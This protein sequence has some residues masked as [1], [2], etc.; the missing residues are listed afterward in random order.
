M[1]GSSRLPGDLPKSLFERFHRLAAGDEITPVY[2]YGRHR[3]DPA[4][5]PELLGLANLLGIAARGEY[6]ARGSAVEA[7]FL[8]GGDQYVMVG[9]ALALCEISLEQLMLQRRLPPALFGPMQQAMR[10]ERVVD[11]ALVRHGHG[12]TEGGGTR[13][14]HLAI[15]GGLLGRRAVFLGD[16]L[17]Q[18]LPLGRH[19]G[20]QLEGLE[21][22]VG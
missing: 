19:A 3:V 6:L 14:D 21:A 5:L 20:V 1:T 11:A 4:R 2:D 15:G 9:G 16:M 22:D 7:G 10:V 12:E 13:P 17:D 18:V 8:R